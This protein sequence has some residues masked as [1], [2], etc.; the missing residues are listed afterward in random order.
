MKKIIIFLLLI[1]CL[2]TCVTKIEKTDNQPTRSAVYKEALDKAKD[3]EKK[4]EEINL[5]NEEMLNN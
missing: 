2:S 4:V 1:F 5:I 3:V